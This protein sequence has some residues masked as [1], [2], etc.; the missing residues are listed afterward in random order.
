MKE[1]ELI[2]KRKLR[3]KHFLQEDGTIIA[4]VY[5]KDLHYKKNNKYEEIDNTLVKEKD[6]YCN[7]SND[8]KVYFAECVNDK[9]MRMEKEDNFLEIKIS[10]SKKITANKKEKK[11]K[12]IDNM[13]YENILD[14][15]DIEYKTLPNKVKETIVLHDYKNKKLVFDIETNLE[16]T[17]VNNSIVATKND[18]TIFTIDKPYMEDSKGKINTNISYKLKSKEKN[19]QLELKLDEKWL[20]DEET[21][22]PIYIDPTIVN[23]NQGSGLYDTYIYPGDAS[24]DKNGQAVLKAGIEK[25]N[26]I[27]IE[28]RAL[29]KFDLPEISTGSQIIGGEIY[30]TGFLP[31]YDHGDTQEKLVSVHRIT[32]NWDEQT[33]TWDM[34]NDKFDERVE[35]VIETYRSSLMGTTLLPTVMYGDISNLVNNWYNGQSNYGIMLQTINKNYI[36]DEY[37]AF[38]SKNN[39]IDGDNPQPL[40]A[41]T[42]RN[43]N[44]L[45]DYLD[46]KIQ[47]FTDSTTYVNT[48]NGNM[49][50]VFNIGKTVGGCVPVDL[51][52]IYNTNDVILENNTFYGDGYKLNYEQ[53]IKEV[54]MDN[55]QYLE[56]L[57]SDGTIHY[58]YRDSID[59]NIYYDED[60]LNLKLEKN[61]NKCILIDK[62]DN[63]KMTFEF[64]NGIYYLS[65]ICDLDNNLIQIERDENNRIIKIKDKH[66]SEVLIDYDVNE[67]V[68]TSPN[69]TVNLNIVDNKINS[70]ELDKG[71]IRID[72]NNDNLISS[73]TDVNGLK[74]T[75][76]Y[77]ESKPYRMK[78]VTQYGLNNELGQFFSLE[79]GFNTTK[80]VDH[81]NKNENIIYNSRGNVKSRNNLQFSDDIN[82][83]YSLT[84]KYGNTEG[85]TNKIIS[86]HTP[87]GYVK[88]YLK[89]TSFEND[90]ILYTSEEGINCN[91]SSEY[92]YY[93]NKSLKIVSQ[94]VN[95]IIECEIE[96]PKGKYYT[97]SGYFKNNINAEIILSYVNNNGEVIIEKN[98][99][100]VND[101]FDREEVT[102]Y[103]DNMATSKLKIQIKLLSSGTMYV[104][105]VQLEEGEVANLY[106]FIENSDFSEGYEDWNCSSSNEELNQSTFDI[107]RFNN[108]QNTALKVSMNPL[109]GCGFNKRFPINGKK[110]DLYTISFWYKNSGIAAYRP[111]GGN[112]V[113][114]TFFPVDGEAEYCFIESEQ[115]NSNDTIWQYFSH[116]D[117]ALEDF[118]DI[119]IAFIQQDQANEFY[120]TNISLFHNTTSGFYEYDSN[121]NIILIENESSAT[122]TFTYDSNNKLVNMTDPKGNNIKYEYDN[123]KKDKLLST[124]LSSGVT[125]QLK[126]DQNGNVIF[127]KTSKKKS[128]DLIDGLYKIRS[129]GTDKY[130]KAELNCVVPESNDCS[131]TIWKLEKNGDCYKIIYSVVPNYSISHSDNNIALLE[132]NDNNQFFIEETEDGSYY[133][134]KNTED[135]ENKYLRLNNNILELST[136]TYD[137]PNL[138]FYIEVADSIFTEEKKSYTSDGKFVTSV[139]DS[140]FNKTTFERDE[141]TGLLTSVTDANGIT[142]N[143]TY[144]EKKQLSSINTNG[145]NLSYEYNNQNLI[146][147]V[148]TNNKVYNF[149][150]NNFLKLKKTKLGEI[151]F[152]TNE[153]DVNNGNLKSVIYGNNQE[154]KYY[155]DNFNRLIKQEAMNDTYNYKYD[156]NGNIA[157]VLSNNYNEKYS[158]DKNRRLYKYVNGNYRID[159]TYDQSNNVNTK[160]HSIGNIYHII[161]NIYNNDDLPIETHIDNINIKYN[162]DELGRIIGQAIN[163]IPIASYKYL[164]YGKRTTDIVEEAIISGEK[165]NYE[166]DRLKNISKI[167]INNQLSK[168][169]NYDVFNELIEEKNYETNECIEYEYDLSGNLLSQTKRDLSNNFII[170]TETYL[171]QNNMWP[172][173]LTKYNN[174]D[175]TYDLIGNP[176]TIGNNISLTWTNGRTLHTFSNSTNNM[177][178]TY[179]YN[180]NGIRTSKIVN[181]IETKYYLDNYSIIYQET[182]GETIYYLYD[183]EGVIGL[184]HNNNTYYYIKNLQGDIIGIMNSNCERIASYEYDSWGKLLSVKDETGNLIT[185]AN[186][187]A[188]INP[189]RY[190]SYFY[191][192]E[193]NL[194]YLNSRYYNPEWKRFINA[195]AIIC[196]NKDYISSNLYAYVSN[197]PIT[198]SD[199]SGEGLLGILLAGAMIY[200]AKKVYNAIAK[201]NKDK[202]KSGSST[203]ISATTG[204]ATKPSGAVSITHSESIKTVKEYG[205]NGIAQGSLNTSYVNR[206]FETSYSGQLGFF[207]AE[208][209]ENSIEAQKIVN[210]G[211]KSIAFT[212]GYSDGYLYTGISVDVLIDE[213]NNEYYSTYVR[214]N[215]HPAIP[216]LATAAIA[217]AYIAAPYVPVIVSGFLKAG[218]AIYGAAKALQQWKNAFGM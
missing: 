1:I 30:L 49:T 23:N 181:G 81:S 10:D 50:A 5:D 179:K 22:F 131:N 161:E 86:N 27:D 94:E 7:K 56:Y 192:N 68:I 38:F 12:F 118:T 85:D 54:T 61:D 3:E 74:V 96:V 211:D 63:G 11:S 168:E 92:A 34:M 36:D 213:E 204:Y 141:D 209:G 149:E 124:T 136:F 200:G 140:A 138:K 95:K 198:L 169:Y 88:N 142:T 121:G 70:I 148:I 17:E 176:L 189:F 79:Y 53:T 103:Y 90:N 82:N 199:H 206:E 99:L 153:Y 186:H 129:K 72:Y 78:K 100:P 155:Y 25:V 20:M 164:Q 66:N 44:G 145:R 216:I 16:L 190:R 203:A 197:N 18:K 172:D 69:Q 127:S 160:K 170:S 139:T 43:Q 80:I 212:K 173:Q 47:E 24:A 107:V 62:Y 76:E 21:T 201:A 35:A 175:I 187:I 59:N 71:T 37:A 108:N 84:Q 98:S 137:D 114:I 177:N 130:L 117:Y 97:Y 13:I 29:I 146:N 210:I 73:I 14:G 207:G 120:V 157:K 196:S 19:Y 89:N 191:D 112:Y 167:Y 58:F 119:N 126:Y 116:S 4:R 109:Y 111:H 51:K 8:Y 104:D 125:T 102:I 150:Y 42:Y 115:L 67:I 128:N 41:I 46:Y 91:I 122:N 166:Y 33:A 134:F 6:Y 193:T 77:F 174:D 52:L 101:S 123:V 28:N 31:S 156:K 2:G 45:E 205:I 39:T 143:Y 133:I 75:Y 202:K 151:T 194:Y 132:D 152:A 159:Y 48:L 180:S 83:A 105:N 55:Q 40:L 162:N 218:P 208:Y 182:N 32:Q 147:K 135:G 215:V 26:G 217:T 214:V 106:N 110:G 65:E 184:I 163:E 113:V 188:L 178:I 64:K 183:V 144:N 171:Y 185:D 9:L 87:V 154:I 60:G 165:Y 158:Y 195:D 15:I 93:G 57:D